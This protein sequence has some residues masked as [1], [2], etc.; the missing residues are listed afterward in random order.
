MM[1]DSTLNAVY[2]SFRAVLGMADQFSRLRSHLGKVFSA[3][4]IFRTAKWAYYKLLYMLG[5]LHRFNHFLKTPKYIFSFQN[6]GLRR[7]NPNNMAW[8]TAALSSAEALGSAGL[9]TEAD[10]KKNKSSW[11][12]ML[13]LA[14]IIS[15]PYFI[16]RII[17]T[18]DSPADSQGTYSQS[19][20]LFFFHQLI[21]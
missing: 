2:S 13:F 19:C 15:A 4:A 16:W 10:I 12:I 17:S 6:T 3:L 7:E 14:I 9:L 21:C 5:N 20:F 8:N 1:L 18:L 11:P